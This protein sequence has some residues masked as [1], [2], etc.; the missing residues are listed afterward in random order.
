MVF[1]FYCPAMSM[2]MTGVEYSHLF[3]LL[4]S[5]HDMRSFTAKS[6]RYTMQTLSGDCLERNWI[7]TANV[8]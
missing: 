2:S 8:R 3:Y 6:E 5:L 7:M 1:K 4:S